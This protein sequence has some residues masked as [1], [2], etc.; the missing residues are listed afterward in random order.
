MRQ[1]TYIG[2]W[3]TSLGV[4]LA[5]GQLL[6][7]AVRVYDSRADF[8]GG[9]SAPT[10]VWRYQMADTSVNAGPYADIPYWDAEYSAWQLQAGRPPYLFAISW[11]GHPESLYDLVHTFLA[12]SEGV[13]L[14]SAAIQSQGGNGSVFSVT[15]GNTTGV[16]SNLYSS[17]VYP[18]EPKGVLRKVTI[19][20]A[21]SA[22]VSNDQ[23][24]FRV[25]YNGELNND[26]V[27]SRYM[28]CK[29]GEEEVPE[30]Y[31]VTLATSFGSGKPEASGSGF[32]QLG[33]KDPE[34]YPVWFYQIGLP[35]N[36]S[37][38]RLNPTWDGSMYTAGTSGESS[39]CIVGSDFVHPGPTEAASTV[40]TYSSPYKT[41]QATI[42]CNASISGNSSDGVL[43]RI[44]KNDTLLSGLD[45]LS[46]GAGTLGTNQ[47]ELVAGDCLHVT[48]SPKANQQC[49]STQLSVTITGR[50]DR[51]N[52][53][54]VFTYR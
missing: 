45:L 33:D 50:S 26:Q 5:S 43:I 39:Y 27:F 32:G 47:V 9:P 38:F 53:G 16:D 30:D 35:G 40:V 48:V 34:G 54:P 51:N 25:N 42:A 24:H 41:M 19:A 6:S 4:L 20:G 3:I 17:T 29:L 13:Y 10:N 22:A 44:Y 15:R 36:S 8:S 21:T 49:D 37:T 2:K 14:V 7:A 31:S 28:V 1:T 52:Q 12:P 18:G 11:G 46:G 23:L